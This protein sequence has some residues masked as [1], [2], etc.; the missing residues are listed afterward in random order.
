MIFGTYLCQWLLICNPNEAIILHNVELITKHKMTKIYTWTSSSITTYSSPI[1]SSTILATIF[2]RWCFSPL[3]FPKSNATGFRTRFPSTPRGPSTR[4]WNNKWKFLH[5][6]INTRIYIGLVYYTWTFSF[7]TRSSCPVTSR[8]FLATIFWSCGFSPLSYLKSFSTSP[9]TRPS[10]WG[11]FT[12]S[13]P[14][15]IHWNT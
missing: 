3:S 7:I 10:T 15:T 2:G 5:I 1:T 14:L 6:N 4:H 12:P 8:T 11:P 9:R 13:R